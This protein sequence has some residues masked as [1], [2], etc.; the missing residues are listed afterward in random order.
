MA[1]WRASMRPITEDSFEANGFK[2]IANS[3]RNASIS[4]SST[5]GIIATA[6]LKGKPPSNLSKNKNLFPSCLPQGSHYP[7]LTISQ[8]G[9][10]PSS[11]L[12]EAIENSIS[13]GNILNC[14]NHLFILTFGLKS[15]RS[16]IKFK[17]IWAMSWSPLSHT[18]YRLGSAQMLKIG[19]L[20]ID[21][22]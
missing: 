12:S 21:T 8:M 13:L 6:A 22:C 20:C 16:C 3:G 14:L 18:V 19:N 1:W 9:Q 17:S 11:V 15:S 5:I 7:K 2:A 4:S 10:Y